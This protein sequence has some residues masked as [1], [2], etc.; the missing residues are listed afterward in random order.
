LLGQAHVSGRAGGAGENEHQPETPLLVL[1]D[2]D[3]LV[4]VVINLVQ[5]ALKFTPEDGAITV[6]VAQEN[7][8]HAGVTVRDTGPG[9]P[10]ECLEKIFDPFFRVAATRRTAK[11]LGLGLSIVRTLVELHGGTIEARCADSGGAELHFTLPLR[12]GKESGTVTS[13]QHR[14]ILVV[15]DDKDIRDL[16]EDRLCAM[17]YQVETETDGL[18]ALK[19]A[20]SGRFSGMI[21]DIGLPSLDGME[22]LKQ[23]RQSDDR[24][25]II[26]V[27]ASGAKETAIKAI[28]LGA[29]GYLLKP[30]DVEELQQ[31]IASCL[32]G[33]C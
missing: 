5:N 9:I 17:G 3:R 27:T 11:G 1:A 4:Q 28:S 30:F 14:C 15:D 20:A 8:R 26:M 18:R 16:L 22:V 21:L 24:L 10:P 13:D 19:A 12:F 6:T 7:H 23:I 32:R 25:P 31:V 2:R 33:G 29:Q